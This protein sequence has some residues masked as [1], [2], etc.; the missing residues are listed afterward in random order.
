M[1]TLTF[2][3]IFI[4]WMVYPSNMNK[5]KVIVG[6]VI[7]VAVAA[8][9]YGTTQRYAGQGKIEATLTI[10]N[11]GIT[12]HSAKIT[13]GSNVLDLMTACNIPFEEDSGLVTSING[14]SQDA[15][16]GKYWLYYVNGEFAQVGAKDYIVQD[17]DEITWKLESF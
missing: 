16:A 15:D 17:G 2:T 14:I 12:T 7:I 8:V 10:E 5:N 9:L 3:E 6:V 4:R 13:E 11:G 1:F